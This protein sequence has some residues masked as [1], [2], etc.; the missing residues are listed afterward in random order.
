[1]ALPQGWYWDTLPS[2]LPLFKGITFFTSPPSGAW[3]ASKAIDVSRSLKISQNPAH[4]VPTYAR[5]RPLKIGEREFRIKVFHGGFDHIGLRATGRLG[6]F[7]AFLKFFVGRLQNRQKVVDIRPGVLFSLMPPLRTFFQ[8]FIVAFFV[9]LDEAFET[10][11]AAHLV[12]EL[13]ALQQEEKARDPA[14][15]VAEGV[16]AQKIKVESR[17]S[18]ERMNPFLTQALRPKRFEFL[19]V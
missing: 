2:L 6:P 3:A 13:I 1:M 12:T 19:H 9:L 18:D 4:H 10:D 7:Q 8:G 17:K 5:T 14:V 11:I 15:A 16:N